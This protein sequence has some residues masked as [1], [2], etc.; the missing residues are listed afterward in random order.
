MP[1]RAGRA[2]LWSCG[3]L[4]AFAAA[5]GLVYWAARDCGVECQ[6][7]PSMSSEDSLPEKSAEAASAP[8]AASGANSATPATPLAN[9][10]GAAG[11]AAAVPTDGKAAPDF[12]PPVRTD[13]GRAGAT[14]G[15]AAASEAGPTEEEAPLAKRPLDRK[16]KRGD[17]PAA[18]V[19]KGG[20]KKVQEPF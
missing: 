17:K 9:L 15:G 8:S 20:K 5:G 18:K 14:P 13:A 6:S 4:A 3:G 7:A 12:I 10:P 1:G 2:I 11:L 19:K 16:G